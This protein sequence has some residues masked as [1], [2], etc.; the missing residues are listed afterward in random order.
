[1]DDH[2]TLL[3]LNQKIKHMLEDQLGGAYWVIAEISELRV[4]QRGHCYL[5]LVEKKDD[6]ILAKMRA[7]IWSYNYRNLSG[8]FEAITGQPLRPGMNILASVTINF[9]EVFGL[10]LNIRDIDA[11]YTLG[12]RARRRQEIMAK[13]KEDGIAEMNRELPLPAVPQR[14]AIIA[15]ATSAGYQD[16]MEQ[17]KGNP[18]N[19]QFHADLFQA[20][21]QG[22]EAERSIIGAMIEIND[23]IDQYDVLVLIR[24]GGASLDL[25]CFDTYNLASHV[26]QFPLPVI[27]GIGHER[28]ET[29]TDMVANTRLK[30]PTAVA[31]FLISGCRQYE[32]RI[33]EL[34]Q[35]IIHFTNHSIM[36]QNSQIDSYVRDIKH[37]TKGLI[38]K[39]RNELGNLDQKF[40]FIARQQIIHIKN[41]IANNEQSIKKSIKHLLIIKSGELH[42]LEERIKILDPASI[43]TRGFSITR[44]N[45]KAIKDPES[46]QEEDM[47]ETEFASGK[48][49]S[50][51][52]K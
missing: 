36:D 50:K 45:N 43:L 44:M 33:D 28:D 13:L 42:N 7:T 49:K 37:M 11:N 17:L 48:I 4:N 35:S 34:F 14:I 25:D 51:I 46:L 1:M 23:R 52:I 9:H 2:L 21:M 5:E 15:S 38:L 29:I 22:L 26:A 41:I 8:W 20:I 24:G 6:Q 19:Y 10:S 16:F 30:T 18:Y 31:E 47:I 12:E 27:T 32:E 40:R 39:K 3:G